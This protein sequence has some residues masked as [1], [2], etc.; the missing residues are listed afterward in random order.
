M[1]IL[2][3]T[4]AAYVAGLIDGE[5]S[6]SI[7]FRNPNPRMREVNTQVTIQV[8]LSMTDEATISYLACITRTQDKV[9][10]YKPRNSRHKTQWAWHPGLDA[11]YEILAQCLPYM[12]TKKRQAEIFIALLG[13]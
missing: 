5:G 12:V 13:C 10:V 1:P 3:P 2:T 4:Q 6:I 11:S 7:N 9:Y 8:R